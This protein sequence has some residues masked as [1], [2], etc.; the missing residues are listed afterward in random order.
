L[1]RLDSFIRRLEAQR[2]CLDLAVALVGDIP[3]PVLELGLGNGRTFDHLRER[4]PGRAI[5]VFERDPRPHP[6]CRPAE[7][8]L[9]VGDLADT[10]PGAPDRIGAAAA[11]LHADLGSADPDRDRA[12]ARLVAR[13]LPGLVAPG[14]VVVADQDLA[15]PG[16][17]PV[18]VP[19]LPP[20]RYFVLRR[21]G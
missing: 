12:L 17:A 6:A 7:E 21:D 1:S 3:G 16:F 8:R 9:I 11:L 14:G 4:L 10:L 20:G 15:A 19:G 18:P 13:H 2:R 5:W